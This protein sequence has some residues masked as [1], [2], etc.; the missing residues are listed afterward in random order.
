M[1]VNKCI[2][3]GAEFET[4][5]PK[6]VICP[7]CLYAEKKA[8]GGSDGTLEQGGYSSDSQSQRQGSY[9][10]GQENDRPRSSYQSRDNGYSSGGYQRRDNYSQGGSYSSGGY[11]RRDSYSQGGGYSSGGYNRDNRGGGYQQRP[12][13]GGYNRDNRGG[14]Y[15]QR[16]QN[17]SYNRD[18]RGGGYQQRS[19]GGGYN[20]DNRGGGFQQRR[21][22]GNNRF[23]GGRKP[24]RPQKQAKP[25]LVTKE[26]LEV[27]EALYKTMLP[28]PNPDAH[29]VIGEKMQLEPRKVFFGINLVRQKL[30]LPKLPYPK[31][32]LAISEDQMLAIKSLYEPLLPL[33]PIGCHKIIATQLRMDEWRVHVG[34]GLIR[35]QMGL[36]R[37][38]QDREDAPEEYRKQKT[39][40]AVE[41]APKAKK[42][43]KKKTSEVDAVEESSVA[44]TEI[45][46][47]KPKKTRTTK[48]KKDETEDVSDAVAEDIEEAPKKKRATRKT[49]KDEE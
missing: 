47:D 42:N 30:M 29:E 1:Y 24:Q 36:E 25:L 3:C 6:R 49:K 7:N 48:K 9:S 2:K 31:R 19:Q 41:E 32:K 27:I 44:V 33:P 22:Q 35:A 43:T 38:N 11:Q 15:Q 46:E 45:E 39:E 20:R 13:G 8:E 17:G 16:P 4:K 18:N 37:W 40:V 28:L 5:N 26:Q 10:F 34:I 12:Q 14:G 23:G 21:P